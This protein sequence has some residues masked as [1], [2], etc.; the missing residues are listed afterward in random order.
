VR[1]RREKTGIGSKERKEGAECTPRRER[2]LS[3]CGMERE[4]KERRKILNEDG[5]DIRSMKEIW[6]RREII[7]KE[8]GG[9]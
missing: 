5:R 3:T 1:T 2:Q 8:K 7:E 6:K 9:V 4:R